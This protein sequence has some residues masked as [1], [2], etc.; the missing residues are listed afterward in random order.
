[1]GGQWGV[2]GEPAHHAYELS[3]AVSLHVVGLPATAK[4]TYPRVGW[5]CPVL[6]GS[7]VDAKST[8]DR[9]I[10]LASI[11][12]AFMVNVLMNSAQT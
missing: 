1:M 7:K 5:P 6:G 3:Q 4:I 11:R 12:T 10:A 9:A 2:A 8:D